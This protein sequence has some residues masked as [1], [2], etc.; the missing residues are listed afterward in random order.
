M[1]ISGIELDP[2]ATDVAFGKHSMRLVLADGRE[3][4]VPLEWVPR[5]GDAAARQRKR[6]RLIGGGEEAPRQVGPGH[7]QG[8]AT[9]PSAR[10]GGASPAP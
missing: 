5:L 6:W 2:L 7:A 1:S 4:S 8:A 10:G 3:I 9:A